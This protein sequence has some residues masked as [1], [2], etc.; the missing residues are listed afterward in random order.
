VL[1]AIALTCAYAAAC[2]LTGL[3]ILRQFQAGR[4]EPPIPSSADHAIRFLFGIAVLAAVWQ[5]LGLVS[6]FTPALI[7]TTLVVFVAHGL[8]WLHA[9]RR[10]SAGVAKKTASLVRLPPIWAILALAV[11]GAWVC[12]AA[13]ALIF[14][15]GGDA[16]AFY[17]VLP[18]IM[19]S[20]ER[21][22]PQ[23]NYH[24]FSQIGLLG[25]MHFAALFALQSPMAAKLLVPL[26]GV[27]TLGL[28][29]AFCEECGVDYRGKIVAALI[30]CSSTAFMNVL[31]VGKV[32]AF[33]A[34][35][36]LA[37]FWFALDATSRND[38]RAYLVAGLFT[39][40]AVVAKFSNLPV[41]G[42]GIL[43]LWLSEGVRRSVPWSTMA[44]HGLV[45]GCGACLALLP[46]FVKNVVLFQEPFAPFLFLHE[47]GQHWA[48]QAWLNAANTRY[49]LL[50]YP[51][52]LV[53]GDYP[54][55][56]GTMS[57]LILALVPVG[58]IVARWSRETTRPVVSRLAIVGGIGV[59]TWMA[60]RPAVISP[61]Y[62]LATLLL[63]APVGGW[64]AGMIFRR[65]NT[66]LMLKGATFLA[67]SYAAV[68]P[69][70]DHAFFFSTLRAGG[71]GTGNCVLSASCPG[72]EQMNA[73]A[74][75]GERIYFLGHYAY[76]LRP[77]L[78]Q[79]M[80]ST[81][82]AVADWPALIDRGFKYVVVQK[83]SHATAAPWLSEDRAPPWLN[84][85]VLYDDAS[86]RVFTLTVTDDQY[87]ATV[88]CVQEPAPA[89]SVVPSR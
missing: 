20:S 30:V 42:A 3:G 58:F 5:G 4:Q 9:D 7:L 89:W 66:S 75:E 63:F 72:L 45:L 59:L 77:D 53:Y 79:C 67:L 25:E 26:V 86:T 47:T 68:L 57:P 6:L 37:A 62:I 70:L 12:T 71:Y 18:K 31:W 28:I 21:L 74:A 16:E 43:F 32:D 50:T 35:L 51:L 19:A 41:L 84:V 40:F 56:G 76:H 10:R 34:A 22:V 17:M 69:N 11:V 80:N 88:K 87:Q 81:D 48:D 14:S 61:R 44:K 52:A 83:A 39:G 27:A 85:R 24:D 36:G 23:P 8:F 60:V 54:M 82:D 2:W 73:A 1:A 46:H 65:A 33:G 13:R 38:T 15:A 49:L 78:L 55:Q 29:L 64:A